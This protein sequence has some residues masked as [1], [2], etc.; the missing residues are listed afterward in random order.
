MRI[1]TLRKTKYEN[2]FIYVMQFEYVFQ[3]LFS[4]G[5]EIYQGN[6]VFHP[7]FFNK[8]KYQLGFIKSPYSMDEV[9]DA[10][11]AVLSG[12]MA[13]IDTIIEEG[14]KTRQ[15]EKKKAKQIKDIEEDIQQ[16]SQQKCLWRAIE[17]RDGFYYECL[18]HSMLVKMKDGEQ[19][20]HDSTAQAE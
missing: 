9:E 5:N 19:P 6:I 7:T 11:K 4:W 18:T 8:I 10:E 2:T 3:Y 17:T 12:A 1:T 20:E 13:S 15:F 14:G 16:R